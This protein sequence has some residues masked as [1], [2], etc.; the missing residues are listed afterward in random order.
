MSEPKFTPGPWK[1]GKS[2]YQSQARVVAE[3]GGR[4]ADVFAY[5]EDQAYANAVLIAAAPEMYK[6]LLKLKECLEGYFGKT[7]KDFFEDC[8]EDS[9]ELYFAAEYNEAINA[10]KTARGEK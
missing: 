4:I 10:L 8:N 6:A 9:G 3:K 1:V 7:E 2:I 5:E